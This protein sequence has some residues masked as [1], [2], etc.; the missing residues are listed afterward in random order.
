MDSNKDAGEVRTARQSLVRLTSIRNLLLSTALGFTSF[1][2][3]LAAVPLW[4][5]QEGTPGAAAGTVTSAM[6]ASTIVAQ[7]MVPAL[8]AKIGMN[9]SLGLGLALLTIPSL[10]YLVWSD[11][12][13]LLVVSVLR[14]GGF[15]IVTVVGV[16]LATTLAPPDRQGESVGLFG[17]AAS[18]PN[19]LGVPIGVLL[20]QIGEFRWVALIAA[21]PCLATPII[22]RLPDTE[23]PSRMS[24]DVHARQTLASRRSLIIS[25]VVLFTTVLAYGGL[26][27]FLPIERPEGH[28][29]PVG[30]LIVGAAAAFMRWNI[31][32]LSDRLGIWQLTAIAVSGA[33]LGAALMGAG[34][35]NAAASAVL[36]IAGCAIFGLSYGALQTL[37]LLMTMKAAGVERAATASATWNISFDAGLSVGAFSI[38]LIASTQIGAAGSFFAL[39]GLLAVNL[40]LAFWA[41]KQFG[42]RPN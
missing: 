22:M 36:L 3:P 31:G 16:A 18:L 27:T 8:A 40:P 42:A 37:T 4:A 32:A 41:S 39:A 14:G 20:T 25:S 15:A 11:L 9:R 19:L 23:E 24:T 10:L 6:L 5:V 21:A 33:P 28:V 34:L 17:L 1:S 13:A 38:G 2:L 12:T 30:L 26:I 29:A 35:T 7:S